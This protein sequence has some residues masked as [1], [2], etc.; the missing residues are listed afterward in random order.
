MI[1]E[2]YTFASV[3]KRSARTSRFVVALFI[4]LP[5]SNLMPEISSN[6]LLRAAQLPK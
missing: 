5:R 3:P 6:K 2:E 1:F 4:A